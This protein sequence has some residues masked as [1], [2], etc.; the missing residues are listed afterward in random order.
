MP[1]RAPRI[2]NC[3]HRVPFGVRCRCEQKQDSERKARFDQTRPN[4]S[5]R[6]YTGAWDKAKAAFLKRHPR[7][8]ICGGRAVLVD[9]KAP[10]K[11]NREL[12][13][14]KNNWQPLCTPCHSGAKQRQ[15]R[16]NL[17]EDQK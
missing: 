15:E 4:S 17:H 12:F 8:A 2:C 9:H 14:D 5:Q 11:G 6:G 10:H 3:G 7:C 16:R 13:W 1:V